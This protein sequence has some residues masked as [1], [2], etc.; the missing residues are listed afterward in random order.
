MV[1]RV[2]LEHRAGGSNPS[3]PA[4]ERYKVTQV[5]LDG[6]PSRVYYISRAEYL[7][8]MNRT[9]RAFAEADG[10]SGIVLELADKPALNSGASGHPG[11][12]P[13]DP[14]I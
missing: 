14:T 1:E 4:T 3:S 5:P 10:L 7:E 12:S 2:P 9:L 13:G 8:R 6:S 11:S